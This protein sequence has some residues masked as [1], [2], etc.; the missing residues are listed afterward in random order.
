MLKKNGPCRDASAHFERTVSTATMRLVKSAAW[1][2]PQ[3]FVESNTSL[4]NRAGR[5]VTQKPVVCPRKTKRY[6]I[7]HSQKTQSHSLAP[8]AAFFRA[9][10]MPGQDKPATKWE[11]LGTDAKAATKWESLDTDVWAGKLRTCEFP[12]TAK[13]TVF[14]FS[15]KC[16]QPTLPSHR[17]LTA[18]RCT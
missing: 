4:R 13:Q 14:F 17:G 18:S 8:R 2:I 10:P 1:S 5:S 16:A 15:F 3:A 9:F 7:R 11:S 6:D 12:K